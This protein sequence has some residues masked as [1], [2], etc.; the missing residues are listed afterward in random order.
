MPRTGLVGQQ[1]CPHNAH[2]LLRMLKYG[3]HDSILFIRVCEYISSEFKGKSN[4][5]AEDK[6]GACYRN[7][8]ANNSSCSTAKTSISS[9]KPYECI[10][11]PGFHGDKCDQQID[12]CF[13]KPC[14]NNAVCQ[15]VSQGHY[16]SVN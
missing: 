11:A 16:R 4:Q 13:G 15:V 14:R 12:A 5:S 6:C 9:S 7:A 2:L 3:I 10:C 8:C 1:T